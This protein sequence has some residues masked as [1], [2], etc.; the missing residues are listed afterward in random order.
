MLIVTCKYRHFTLSLLSGLIYHFLLL[1]EWCMNTSAAEPTWNLKCSWTQILQ[2]VSNE[3]LCSSHLLSFPLHDWQQGFLNRYIYKITVLNYFVLLPTYWGG[4][5]SKI[6]NNAL[7][8]FRIMSMTSG[9]AAQPEL[10][11]SRHGFHC[12]WTKSSSE[13]TIHEFTQSNHKPVNLQR[14]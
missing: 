12:D 9:I 3:F 11:S 8:K 14:N 2:N 7:A 5:Y 1:Q 6:H 10:K 4:I 13:G